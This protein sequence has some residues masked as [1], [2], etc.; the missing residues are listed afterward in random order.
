VEWKRRENCR[1]S[2]E[3]RFGA[4]QIWAD[5]F[6]EAQPNDAQPKCYLKRVSQVLENAGVYRGGE[7]GSDGRYPYPEG[8]PK[9]HS[10][11]DEPHLRQERD[12]HGGYGQ[13]AD[14]SRPPAPLRRE[15]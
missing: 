10:R 6:Q 7:D 13:Y 12:S 15:V 8:G 14:G 11:R 1:W 2:P 4:E 9:V 5:C 3:R